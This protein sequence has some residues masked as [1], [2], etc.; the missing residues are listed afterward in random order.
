MKG[1]IFAAAILMLIL[2]AVVMLNVFV[3][4]VDYDNAVSDKVTYPD[5]SWPDPEDWEKGREALERMLDQNK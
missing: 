4:E 3:P 5:P 1:K 2:S